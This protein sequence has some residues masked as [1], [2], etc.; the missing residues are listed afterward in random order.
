MQSKANPAYNRKLFK[1]LPNSNNMTERKP[2]VFGIGGLLEKDEN[3]RI[4][5]VLEALRQDGC[6]TYE[7]RFSKICRNGNTIVCPYSESWIGDVAATIETGLQDP[8]VDTSRIGLIG[9]SLGT[10]VIDQYLMNHRTLEGR[11]IAYAAIAPFSRVNPKIRPVL[12]QMRNGQKD[13]PIT[14][15]TDNE[16]GIER[17]IPYSSL[18]DILKIDTPE[19]LRSLGSAYQITPFTVYGDRDERVEVSSIIERHNVL[20]GKNENLVV[21]PCG[22]T[23]PSESTEKAKEFLRNQLLSS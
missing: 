3:G 9:S 4:T 6:A 11:D 23:P 5:Q 14:S 1:P 20:R 21:Y 15:R 19:G 10:A 8:S 2:V 16:R 12:E 7:V 22:H 17:I 13:M 18:P